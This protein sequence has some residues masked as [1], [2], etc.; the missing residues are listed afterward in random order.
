MEYLIWGAG[1][2]G[3]RF[4]SLLKENEALAFLDTDVKKQGSSIDG[5]LVMSPVDGLE[6]F[7]QAYVLVS[8]A[9]NQE[10]LQWLEDHRIYGYS[11]MSELPSEIQ[12]GRQISMENFSGELK[13]GATIA[14]Y[15]VNP[16]SFWLYQKLSDKGYNVF[17]V[18]DTEDEKRVMF[19]QNST[20]IE[21]R[22]SAQDADIVFVTSDGAERAAFRFP[23]KRIENLAALTDAL[24]KYFH[25]ELSQFR[26]V[27]KGER[28]FLVGMGPSLRFADLEK[29]HATGET[30]M[31]VNLAYRAFPQTEWRPDYYVFVDV[32]GLREFGDELKALD[33][34]HI[35][36]ADAEPTFWTE[37]VTASSRFHKFHLAYP[38]AERSLPPFSSDICNVV[39]DA[40]TVMIDALQIAVYMGFSEIYIIGADCS[41]QG[42]A[43]RQGNHFI[44]NYYPPEMQKRKVFPKF[45][46]DM[47]F[48]GYQSARRYAE[49]HGIQIFNA[50]RGGALEVFPRVDFDALF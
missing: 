38:V 2:R 10:I 41:Y 11:S 1:C 49:Q 9:D 43:E 15:G 33:V 17:I 7:P 46:P 29:I 16:W 39:Y 35:F 47:V 21:V 8:V 37:D 25:P 4:R 13:S 22:S 20:D 24:Q 34:P 45:F 27:H 3:R 48:R 31:S 28:L 18:P 44:R 36:V 26:N 23:E 5:T 14:I 50:T 12:M 42:A 19:L 6:K 32:Y 40:G 30:S